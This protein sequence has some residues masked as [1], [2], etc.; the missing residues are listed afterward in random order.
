VATSEI[1]QELIT[2]HA[3]TDRQT[4]YQIRGIL[5]EGGS[6]ITY[7]A[8]IVGTDRLVALKEL[9][10]QQMTDWKAL[11]LFEREAQVLAKLDHPAIPKYIDYFAIDTPQNRSFYIVQELAPGKTLAA[12]LKTGWRCKEAEVKNIAAQLLEILIY[13]QGLYPPVV[14]RDL[15]PSNILRT[16]EGKISLVDFGA[17]QQTYHNTFMRGSTV[18]GTFGYM[19]PEQFRGQA[20]PATDLYGL[21]A[22]ILS[23]LTNRSPAELAAEELKINF[24]SQ[25]QVSDG[26]ADWL[27]KMLEP[28]IA[29]RFTSATAALT[30]LKKPPR[31]KST[32][33]K[34]NWPQIILVSLGA[35]ASL[36]FLEYYKYYFLSLGGFTPND[37]FPAIWKDSDLKKVKSFLDRGVNPNSRDSN[38]LSL[39]HN[40]VTSNRLEIVK[41]L[42]EKGVDVNATYGDDDHL[43]LHLAVF[44]PDG[45]MTKLLLI[46]KANVNA[47]NRF[48]NTPINT[49]CSLSL[50]S[51]F[52]KSTVKIS[53]Y[54]GLEHLN[55]V[56]SEVPDDVTDEVLYH[57]GSQSGLSPSSIRKHKN[58]SI[59][60][61]YSIEKNPEND[62]I[63]LQSIKH[64]LEYGADSS[65]VA[66]CTSI[67]YRTIQEMRK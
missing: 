7:R 53:S 31:K 60:M 65:K 47:M 24:R 44:H 14:H 13:L 21:G 46:N 49:A 61:Q 28:D 38:G 50:F 15:K 30:E 59:S 66:G 12:W 67:G 43:V 64:L 19:A 17:V 40:A 23:L 3:D 32:N 54:H 25:I 48:K 10:L 5:G 33:S 35:F 4:Q 27:E 42:I 26:F 41:L 52:E 22:T 2:A 62:N 56:L 39:L 58:G 1:L 55:K 29:N 57:G 36:G 20:L 11:E 8:K 9:S 16:A 45:E 34:S 6:G 51:R 18:V 63:T 37:I